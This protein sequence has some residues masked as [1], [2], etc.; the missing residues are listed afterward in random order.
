[1]PDAYPDPIE[2][3]LIEQ[4]CARLQVEYALTADQG[5]VEG[6]TALFAED[7]S[8]EVPEAPA[9][10]GHAAIRVSMQALVEQGLT[11]RHIITNSL[12]TVLDSGAAVGGC[13]L[14]VYNSVEAANETGAR[15]LEMPATVGEYADEFIL[16]SRGWR[17]KSRVL[18]RIFQRMSDAKDTRQIADCGE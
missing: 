11:M 7:G 3:L 13:Y 10:V 2:R 8:V 14:T 9:F 18:R 12:V 5:D 6:F 16:T 1:M 15:P 17:I 4:A